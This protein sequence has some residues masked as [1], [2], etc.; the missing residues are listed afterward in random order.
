[1]TLLQWRFGEVVAT[2]LWRP[3]NNDYEVPLT[4]NGEQAGN[5][6]TREHYRKFLTFFSVWPAEN[7]TGALDKKTTNL[8]TEAVV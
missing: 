5:I 6:N 4:K 3:S 2:S 7:S 1:M 8:Q